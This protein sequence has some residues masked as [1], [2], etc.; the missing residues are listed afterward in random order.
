M[1]CYIGGTSLTIDQLFSVSAR[2]VPIGEY[3]PPP[4]GHALAQPNETRYKDGY[5]YADDR[6]TLFLPLNVDGQLGYVLAYQRKVSVQRRNYTASLYRSRALLP[7]YHCPRDF[8]RALQRERDP[9]AYARGLKAYPLAG[10]VPHDLGAGKDPTEQ[11]LS[12]PGT[13]LIADYLSSQLLGKLRV[14]CLER[15]NALLTSSRIEDVAHVQAV[16]DDLFSQ[17]GVFGVVEQDLRSRGVPVPATGQGRLR[18]I[19]DQPVQFI[20]NNRR[21]RFDIPEAEKNIMRQQVKPGIEVIRNIFY[22]V[23]GNLYELTNAT[24]SRKPDEQ[25]IKSRENPFLKY[26][27]VDK[28]YINVAKNYN[29]TPMMKVVPLEEVTTLNQS[30]LEAVPQFSTKQFVRWESTN[31]PTFTKKQLESVP[32][33]ESGAVRWGPILAVAAAGALVLT[34]G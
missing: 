23:L 20:I 17:W 18:E 15:F 7:D 21:V 33:S 34:Q 10:I 4:Y 29:N 32:S 19:I 27:P 13:R 30:T 8:Y 6:N 24:V 2:E 3:T 11:N 9:F 26:D 31:R 1:A 5:P 28:V 25:F 14:Y 12:T 22:D 16:V